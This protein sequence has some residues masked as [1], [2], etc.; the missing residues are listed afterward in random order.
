MDDISVVSVKTHQRGSPMNATH[1]H[2][3]PLELFLQQHPEMSGVCQYHEDVLP[4]EAVQSGLHLH[5]GIFMNETLSRLN[6]HYLAPQ[7][8]SLR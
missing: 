1:R 3:C 5:R 4:G 7:S 8:A 6:P 2:Q